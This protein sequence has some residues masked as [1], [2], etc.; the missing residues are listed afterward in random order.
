MQMCSDNRK[1][2]C[3]LVNPQ[4]KED[5]YLVSKYFYSVTVP[6]QTLLGKKHKQ[7][8]FYKKYFYKFTA[9]RKI[10]LLVVQYRRLVGLEAA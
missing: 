4:L 2:L 10:K 7:E 5:R 8:S 3:S 1:G 6:Q 9:Q